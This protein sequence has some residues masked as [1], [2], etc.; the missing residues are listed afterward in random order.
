MRSHGRNNQSLLS[1]KFP[2]ID[3]SLNL[4]RVYFTFEMRAKKRNINDMFDPSKIKKFE[5]LG[6]YVYTLSFDPNT[7][8]PH[9]FA[10]RLPS[11]K[12][13][14]LRQLEWYFSRN[15][16]AHVC[17]ENGLKLDWDKIDLENFVTIKGLPGYVSLSHT[18][19]LCALAWCASPVGIDIEDITR[20]VAAPV[21]PR[22]ISEKD[23]FAPIGDLEKW[24]VK[25]AAYKALLKAGPRS[26]KEVVIKED[27]FYYDNLSGTYSLIKL[28]GHLLALAK[29]EAG[30]NEVGK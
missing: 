27:S 24:C 7:P 5:A 23:N 20:E 8:L 16:L 4:L 14:K 12:F 18:R 25:E 6:C 26:L 13:G 17:L 19:G 21:L 22:F 11:Q 10:Q 1:P 29:L 30:K 28:E 15:L 9:D 2:G 3:A